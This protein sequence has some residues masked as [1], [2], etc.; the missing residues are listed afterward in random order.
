M[1]PR[2]WLALFLAW[3]LGF[4]AVAFAGGPRCSHAAQPADQAATVHDM[5]QMDMEGMDH[6]EHMAHMSH[7][8][9]EA[10]SLLSDCDCGCECGTCAHACHATTSPSFDGLSFGTL[11]SSPELLYAGVR[12]ASFAT[13]PLR[14]PATL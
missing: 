6:S 9:D 1:R 8:Q 4:Q 14:P 10:P 2:L 3:T 5:A 11:D 12:L 7:G 13:P